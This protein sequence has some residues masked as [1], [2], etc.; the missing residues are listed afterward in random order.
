M[1][2]Q[3][4]EQDLRD[5]IQRRA[6]INRLAWERPHHRRNWLLIVSYP[7][8]LLVAFCL[9]STESDPAFAIGLGLV[10]VLGIGALVAIGVAAWL[11]FT[12]RRQ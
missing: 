2:D 10:V 4:S 1:M 11:Y 6:D 8:L 9:M 12:R 7:F 3:L 5:L